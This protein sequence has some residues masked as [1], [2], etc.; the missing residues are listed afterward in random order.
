M[1]PC[2]AVDRAWLLG[3]VLFAGSVGVVRAL[4]FRPR[5]TPDSSLLLIGD[6]FAGGLG[7]HFNALTQDVDMPYLG[8]GI[9][10]STID[11]WRNSEWLIDKLESRRPS[12]VLIVLGTADAYSDIDPEDAAEDAK[13]LVSLVQAHGAHPLWIGTPP[14]PPEVAG[15]TLDVETTA[16]IRGAVPYYF[17]SDFEIPRGPD[18][19]HPTVAGYAGW[20]GLIWNWIH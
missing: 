6:A 19:L 9:P 8:A 1:L 5:L 12:H 20:T 13:A 10:N 14:L 15:R 17:D 11:Q 4:T 2:P 7:P 3:G 18:G 16:T